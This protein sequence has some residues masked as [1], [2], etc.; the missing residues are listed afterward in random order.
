MNDYRTIRL[1]HLIKDDT[2]SGKLKWNAS[3]QV[4][5]YRLSL[6]IG[7][8]EIWYDPESDYLPDGSLSPMYQFS[9]FND[10]NEVI[11]HI[12]VCIDQDEHYNFLKELYD[13]AQNNYLNKD[14]TFESM[15]EDLIP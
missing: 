5:T 15:F 3:P 1:A 2:K 12:D 13:L 8:V 6:G 14:K 7:M 11:D 4:F 10:R 9:V